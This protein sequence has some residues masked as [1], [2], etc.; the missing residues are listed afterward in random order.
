MN[1]SHIEQHQLFQEAPVLASLEHRIE[2][3]VATPCKSESPA[4]LTTQ[5]QTSEDNGPQRFPLA[6][7]DMLESVEKEGL[8]SIVSWL[9]PSLNDGSISTTFRVHDISKFEKLVLP[10]YFNTSRYK[11]FQ[12]NL[13]V[14]NFSR[15]NRK[16]A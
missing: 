3:N 16:G 6:L 10:K 14:H 1:Q 7:Y 4:D 9:Q 12:R 13:N 15:A 8:N 5:S 11:S 2:R